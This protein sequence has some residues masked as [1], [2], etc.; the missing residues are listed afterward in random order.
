MFNLETRPSIRQLEVEVHPRC[1]HGVVLS[2]SSLTPAPY[3][4]TDTFSGHNGAF[5]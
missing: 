4:Q 1:P 5:N 3:Q 2:Q